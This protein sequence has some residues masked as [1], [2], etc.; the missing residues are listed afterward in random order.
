MATAFEGRSTTHTGLYS[1]ALCIFLY[2]T[3]AEFNVDPKA[4]YTA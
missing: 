4:E 2:D 1:T 3:I